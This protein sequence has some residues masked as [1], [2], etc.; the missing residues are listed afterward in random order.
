MPTDQRQGDGVTVRDGYV[1]AAVSVIEL[2][3]RDEVASGWDQPSA[4]DE[5]TVAGLAGHL[6]GQVFSGVELLEAEPPDQLPIAVDEHYARAAWVTATL[7]EAVNVGI[8]EGG[9]ANA[10][11]GHAHLVGRVVAARERVAELLSSAP[12]NRVVLIPWQGWALALD[13]FLLTRMMEIAVHSDDLAVSVGVAAPQLPESVLQPVIGLLTRLAI[14]R[15]GQSAVLSALTRS[16]RAP[17]SI[18]A[19]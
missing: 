2:L 19:F 7:D 8:R 14:R 13:D 12:E 18:S 6:A 4:L 1:I 16:E 15:H 9:D 10:A 17:D 11:A 5:W 3:S